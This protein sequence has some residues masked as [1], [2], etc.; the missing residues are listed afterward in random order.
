MNSFPHLQT[1]VRPSLPGILSVFFGLASV[2]SAQL[3]ISQ[4]YEG[5]SFD[6]Y[7]ELRNYGASPVLL[8][9]YNLALYT[10][11]N[12]ENWKL[13]VA[14]ASPQALPVG[15]SI[16][17]GGYFLIKHAQ[18]SAPIYASSGPTFTSTP[19]TNF[20]GDDSV[21]L[22]NGIPGVATIADAFSVTSNTAADKSFYRQNSSVG[23]DLTIGTNYTNFP[24]VWAE[25]TLAEVADAIPTDLWYLT[26]LVA[27]NS[28]SLSIT[29]TTFSEAAGAGAATATVTR[30]G[31]TT[32]ALIVSIV[33]SD[34]SE[35]AALATVEILV[36]QASTTF[37][38][39]AVDD[40]IG[41]GPQA[42]N[43]TVSALSFSPAT[44]GIT[45]TDDGDVTVPPSILI[46]QYYEGLA[47][48]KY[49]ELQNITAAPVTLTGYTLTLWTNALSENWKT[50]ASNPNNRLSLSEVTIPAGGYYLVKNAAAA[51]PVAVAAGADTPSAVAGFTGNDSVVLYY[52]GT[53]SLL[54][55]VADAL[56]F[57]NSPI[58]G[59]DTSFYRLTNGVGF[60]NTAGS[61]P[62]NFNLV[63]GQKT[64]SEVNDAVSTDSFFL[65]SGSPN[66]PL[67]LTLLPS[68]IS[69]AAGANASTG[70][71]TRTG[72]LTAS[73][74]VTLSSNNTDE[75]TVPATVTIPS[76][77]A[78]AN[79]S[80]SAVNDTEIDG[81]KM[82]SISASANLYVPISAILTVQDDEPTMVTINEFLS[83]PADGITGD[84][85]GD[86][87]RDGINDE[88]VELV[89]TSGAPIDISGWTLQDSSSVVHT[90]PNPTVLP[91]G[92]AVVVFGGGTPTGAFGGAIVQVSSTLTL[93]LNNAGDSISLVDSS[94]NLIDTVVFSS[95]AAINQSRSLDPDI[96]GN[97]ADHALIAN[98]S[99]ALF[100]PGTRTDGTPFIGGGGGNTYAAWA[101]A[102]ATTG[103]S[104]TADHDNDGVP[105]ALEYFMGATGST[106]TPNPGL[107]ALNKINWPKSPTFVGS[108]TVQT[109]SDLVTWTDVTSAVVGNTVE[110]TLTGPAPKFVRMKVVP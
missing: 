63:W 62:T 7:I 27:T 16:P 89:N 100:S 49:I 13:G 76:N 71:V 95:E 110:Y 41:D 84:S 107:G 106:F 19:G 14:P 36:G 82:V 60:N 87:T 98:A 93:S 8:D 26:G 28:L 90:F 55:D 46:S 108:Y 101:T 10:N 54:G 96:T 30:T 64:I 42:V 37:A 65:N 33:I 29:P 17:A 35:A 43:V 52:N 9:G 2:S 6:K 39:D 18:A 45:V 94:Q 44:A 105:N 61:N 103:A 3:L 78:S 72:N 104:P 77:Q 20:N 80:I 57:P 38:I 68:S 51:T 21:V 69:E 86:A 70:T 22:Y 48:D 24:A 75:A 12:R 32:S 50:G 83:D 88:F 25:K 34:P 53:G 11:A 5:A 74:L 99:G 67:S 109:S 81:P 56:S 59:A 97:F 91:T 58:V 1:I 92:G 102:N 73:L 4:Y 85:N 15:I 40:V 47:N 23:Y 31:P 79:F 66:G